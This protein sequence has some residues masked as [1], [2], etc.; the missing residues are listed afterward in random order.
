M[1]KVTQLVH[2]WHEIGI[3]VV[4]TQSQVLLCVCRV[5]GD[6]QVYVCVCM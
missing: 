6:S 4:L 5:G 2:A 1:H 3:Q